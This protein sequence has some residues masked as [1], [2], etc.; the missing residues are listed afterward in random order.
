MLIPFVFK[1]TK[2]NNFDRKIGELSYPIY[3][4]HVLIWLVLEKIPT[5]FIHNGLFLVILSTIAG[6]LLNHFV[7]EPIEIYRQNKVRL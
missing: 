7:T 5:P 1:K 6:I 4:C 3:I 2:V